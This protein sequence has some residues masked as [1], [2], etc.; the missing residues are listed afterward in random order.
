MYTF[1]GPYLGDGCV[2]A[3][4]KGVWRLRIVQDMR[5]P[6]LIGECVLA[7]SSVTL[8]RVSV[9]PKIGCV[10]IGASWKHWIHPFPQHGP[11]PKWLRP[12]VMEPW[13]QELIEAFPGPLLRGL[14]HSDGCRALNTIRYIKGNDVVRSYAYPRYWFSNNSDDIR[15]LFTDTCERLRVRWTQTSR[16]IVAVSR[17]RDVALLDTF[18]GPKS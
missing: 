11:G 8:S 2:S 13:Q 14:I 12:I 6:G 15:R 18:I 1:L 3:Q 4:R 16:F 5:Y 10:E 9:Q 17:R 7:M